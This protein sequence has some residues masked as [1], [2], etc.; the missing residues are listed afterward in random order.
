M[1][2]ISGLSPG[3]VVYISGGASGSSLTYRV[4]SLGTNYPGIFVPKSGT[5]GNRITYQIGQDAAHNGT[6][7]F[8]GYGIW[9]W[10]SG[11]GSPHDI[12]ISGDAGDKKMHFAITNYPVMGDGSTFT[13]VRI[14]YI[15]CGVLRGGMNFNPAS[16][17][18]FDHNYMYIVATNLDAVSLGSF[19]GTN[20]GNSSMHHCTIFVPNNAGSGPDI[21]DWVGSGFDIYDNVFIGYSANYNSGFH[22]DGWQGQGGRFIRVYNNYMANI[23]N[24]AIYGDSTMSGG[25][26]NLWIYNNVLVNNGGGIVV[27]V[28]PWSPPT[29]RFDNVIIA[30]NLVDSGNVSSGQNFAFGNITTHAAYFTNSLLANNINIGGQ[31]F[32]LPGNSNTPLLRNANFT[33]SQASNSFVYYNA[34]STNSRFH[35]RANAS[36]LIDKG[37]NLNSF[38]KTDKDG[39]TRSSAGPWDIGAHRYL[40]LRVVQPGE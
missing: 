36:T 28:D 32:Y 37:T 4:N 20:W 14:A 6:A 13:N 26:T 2:A 11:N 27:G 10:L 33:P 39:V 5:P 12:V 15:N 17:L 34:G 16:G 30:N 19:A 9:Y 24:Y 21:L 31:A 3:D 29:S 22:M 35:L 25:F 18:E 8:S 40:R 1:D 23:G 7:I 38:F